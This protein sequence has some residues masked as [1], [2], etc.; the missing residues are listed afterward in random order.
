MKR[1]GVPGFNIE[2]LTFFETLPNEL[3]DFVIPEGSKIV[4]ALAERNSKL[5]DPNSGMLLGDMTEEQAS[6]EIT[7]RYWQAIIEGNWQTV[8]I[9][10]PTSTAEQWQ[11]K[12][13]CS[14]FEEIVEIKEPYQEYGVSIVPCKI[15]FEGNVTRTIS[16]SVLFRT[17]DGRQSCVIVN[18]WRRD[19]D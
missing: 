5:Q 1:E 7:R 10:R 18:T 11:N 8:A 12:Y 19:W 13:S 4:P 15:R 2:S 16:A 14:N 3:F 6:K 9:L 17:I